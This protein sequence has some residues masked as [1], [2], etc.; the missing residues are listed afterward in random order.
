MEIRDAVNRIRAD[1]GALLQQGQQFVQILALLEYLNGF[2]KDAPAISQ[3]AE[4]QH[5]SQLAY[6]RAIH[7]TNLEMFKSVIETGQTA[8]T[9]AILI[10]GGGTAALLAFVGNLQT[11]VPAAPVA[12]SLIVA[13]ICFAI[14]VLCAAMGSGARYLAQ[15]SYAAHWRH[16]G[17][18]FHA[19]CIVLVVL[20]YC[21]FA[22][23]V[24]A[25]YHGFIK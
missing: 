6:H 19:T 14:G 9:T 8:V 4:L 3:A 1:L 11:K 7:E 18:G 17:I 22:A 10:C 23:G 25:A 12:Q 15:A 21:L 13:L 24:V 16:S 2:E 20:S 5:Q